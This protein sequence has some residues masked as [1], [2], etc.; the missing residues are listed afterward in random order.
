MQGGKWA[1]Q[2]K[3]KEEKPLIFKEDSEK[4]DFQ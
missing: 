2:R 4:L 1:K 3:G